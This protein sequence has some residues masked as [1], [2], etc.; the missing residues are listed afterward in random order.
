[1][2]REG[3]YLRDLPSKRVQVCSA[4]NVHIVENS[5]KPAGI[6]PNQHVLSKE[7]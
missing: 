5:M 3:G 6:I 7:I 4:Q 1:M 2:K